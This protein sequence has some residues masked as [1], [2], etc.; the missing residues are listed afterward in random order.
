MM[1]GSVR[2]AIEQKQFIA[3]RFKKLAE[4]T[5][6]PALRLI[7]S[8]SVSFHLLIRLNIFSFVTDYIQIVDTFG[9]GP[10][11]RICGF[12]KSSRR[13]CAS[14]WPLRRWQPFSIELCRFKKETAGNAKQRHS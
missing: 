7:P 6:F 4:N 14:W 11:G 5:D 13:D 10:E 8:H 12:Q 1:L 9:H 2:I 3:L